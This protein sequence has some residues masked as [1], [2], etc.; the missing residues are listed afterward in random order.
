MMQAFNLQLSIKKRENKVIF[1]GNFK[2]ESYGYKK[3]SFG[4]CLSTAYV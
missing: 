2:L 1:A 3:N 4:A